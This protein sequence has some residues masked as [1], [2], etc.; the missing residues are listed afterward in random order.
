MPGESESE[1]WWFDVQPKGSGE[2][3]PRQIDELCSESFDWS[4]ASDATPA[5]WY[6]TFATRVASSQPTCR[7]S[8]RPGRGPTQEEQP[9]HIEPAGPS[10]QKQSLDRRDPDLRASTA[11]DSRHPVV[12]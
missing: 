5:R 2:Q 1:E 7:R 8:R 12:R 3:R 6:E 11:H 10:V 4:S 9:R